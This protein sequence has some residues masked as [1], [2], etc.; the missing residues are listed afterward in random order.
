MRAPP[1]SPVSGRYCSAVGARHRVH[2]RQAEPM[3]I[4]VFS[5]YPALEKLGT[6][7]C[8]EA[9]S[10]VLDG[11]L[12]LIVVGIE[13]QVDGASVGQV[14]QL[15]VKQICEHA[16]NESGI[17][18]DAERPITFESHLEVFLRHGGLVEVDHNFQHFIEIHLGSSEPEGIGFGLGN[19]EG[20][21]QKIGQAIQLVNGGDDRL[22]LFAMGCRGERHLEF[23]TDGRERAAQV[24]RQ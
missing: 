11:D 10:V 13:F 21:V 20:F 17:G 6:Y 8:L 16:M 4:G 1:F 24:M 12:S 5:F 19:I 14:L 3:A 7:I 9:G 23:S 22:G 2:K 18:F 15:I